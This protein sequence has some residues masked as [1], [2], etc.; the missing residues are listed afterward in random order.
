MAKVWSG[1]SISLTHESALKF[2]MVIKI[3]YKIVHT[4]RTLKYSAFTLTYGQNT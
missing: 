4:Q 2:I 3:K 1:Y